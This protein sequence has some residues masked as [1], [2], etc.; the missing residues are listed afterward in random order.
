MECG[1]LLLYHRFKMHI[2]LHNRGEFWSLRTWIRQNGDIIG[3][4][5]WRRRMPPVFLATP[6]SD[7]V[8]FIASACWIW[9]GN[10][11]SS[12]FYADSA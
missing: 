11:D 12:R 6:L 4:L 9:Y 2:L 1:L 3:A 7:C 10:D 5:R 8:S